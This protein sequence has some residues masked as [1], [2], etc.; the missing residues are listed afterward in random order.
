MP[1]LLTTFNRTPNFVVWPIRNLDEVSTLID[2]KNVS[3]P[4]SHSAFQGL[5]PDIPGGEQIINHVRQE[6]W[7]V[8]LALPTFYI[9]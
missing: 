1:R 2:I 7:G 4:Q 3:L 9:I 6:F 8:V 5:V